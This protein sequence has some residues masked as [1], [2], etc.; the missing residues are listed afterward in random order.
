MPER[1]ISIDLAVEG[2]FG[3]AVG[4][5]PPFGTIAISAPA[6]AAIAFY[7]DWMNS[8][9]SFANSGPLSSWRKWPVLRMVGCS[10]PLQ[11]GIFSLKTLSKGRPT[12]RCSRFLAKIRRPDKMKLSSCCQGASGGKPLMR[13][14]GG[15]VGRTAATRNPFTC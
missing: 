15:R 11:P 3:V 5:S 2:V 6:S 10:N 13:S 1:Y 12:M 4:L 7:V 14:K 8:V 9:T